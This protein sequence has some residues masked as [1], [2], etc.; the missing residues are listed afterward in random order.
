MAK[1]ILEA[2]AAN[3]R[4]SCRSLRNAGSSAR[5]KLANPSRPRR[6]QTRP[7]FFPLVLFFSAVL[8]IANRPHLP[9][10]LFCSSYSNIT[11]TKTLYLHGGPSNEHKLKRTTRA[12]SLSRGTRKCTMLKPLKSLPLFFERVSHLRS[13]PGMARART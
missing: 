12:L 8:R 11:T 6:S 1:R 4:Y 13:F 5:T 3:P 7:R 10:C 2:P 9:L